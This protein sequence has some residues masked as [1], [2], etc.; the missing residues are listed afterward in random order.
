ML[1]IRTLT[2][3]AAWAGVTA[4]IWVALTLTTLVAGAPPM[5]TP[6]EPPETKLEPV[7]VTGVPPAIGPEG[8]AMLVNVGPAV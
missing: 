3:P 7:I 1:V 4:V 5:V 6:N 8:G 2:A